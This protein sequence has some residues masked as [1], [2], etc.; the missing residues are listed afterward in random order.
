MKKN[1]FKDKGFWISSAVCLLPIL[2]SAIC[3]NSLPDQVATH[4]DF[5]FSPDGYSPK[6]QAAFSERAIA[7]HELDESPPQWSG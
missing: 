3:Y 7:S 4:F 1:I 5:N 2:L 6:W